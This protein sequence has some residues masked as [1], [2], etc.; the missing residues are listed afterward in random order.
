MG[1][2]KKAGGRLPRRRSLSGEGEPDQ[3][4]SSSLLLLSEDGPK[5]C[6]LGCGGLAEDL[7]LSDLPTSHRFLFTSSAAACPLALTSL[8]DPDRITCS[9]RNPSLGL[10]QTRSTRSWKAML[11][12]LL[13]LRASREESLLEARDGGPDMVSE[14]EGSRLNCLRRKRG[15]LRGLSVPPAA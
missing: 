14:K 11:L 7:R 13:P 15:E 2:P 8:K 12:L 9:L 5:G 6:L 4:R 3:P 10:E 1:D